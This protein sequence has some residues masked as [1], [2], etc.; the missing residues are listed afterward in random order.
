AVMADDGRVG[1]VQYRPDRLDHLLAEYLPRRPRPAAPDKPGTDTV[2][3]LLDLG[4]AVESDASSRGVRE[5]WDVVG[6]DDQ[7]GHTRHPESVDADDRLDD[8]LLVAV[9]LAP[10]PLEVLE[11]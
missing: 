10:E 2:P 8:L 6:A 3:L 7:L 9:A 5:V 1:D 11:Q 4:V